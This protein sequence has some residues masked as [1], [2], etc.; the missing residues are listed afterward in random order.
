MA[1]NSQYDNN[2]QTVDESE[3]CGLYVPTIMSLMVSIFAFFFTLLVC[4]GLIFEAYTNGGLFNYDP[5]II[6][7]GIQRF[8]IGG[9]LFA[10]LLMELKDYKTNCYKL[11]ITYLCAALL[12]FSTALLIKGYYTLPFIFFSV[13]LPY[14]CLSSQKKYKVNGR[15]VFAVTVIVILLTIVLTVVI[16]KLGGAIVS[17]A[18]LTTLLIVIQTIVGYKIHKAYGGALK[19]LGKW[20]IIEAAAL[21][22][23]IV[24][25]SVSGYAAIAVGVVMILIDFFFYRKFHKALCLCD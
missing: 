2:K 5:E 24:A 7:V 4:G 20:M 6:E 21:A 23:S 25:V 10:A 11:L 22:I 19:K 17:T 18:V 16:K 13:A 14:S 1:D 3:V 12:M 9:I 15:V 8:G